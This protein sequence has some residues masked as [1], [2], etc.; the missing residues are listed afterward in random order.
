MKGNDERLEDIVDE[1][2]LDIEEHVEK[3]ETEMFVEA[4]RV[5]GPALDL[6]GAK[7]AERNTE[8]LQSPEF[9]PRQDKA[10]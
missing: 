1:L 10:A 3:E 7:M 4:E 5:I 2:I 8:I 9:M 6:L